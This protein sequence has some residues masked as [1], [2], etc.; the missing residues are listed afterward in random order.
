MWKLWFWIILI[1]RDYS[2][3]ITLKD[4]SSTDKPL[5][6]LEEEEFKVAHPEV[7]DR[8]YEKN[9]GIYPQK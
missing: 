5:E 6:L 9:G 8:V 1:S 3:F 2:N 4:L 7:E